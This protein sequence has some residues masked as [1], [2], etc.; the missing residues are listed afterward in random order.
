MLLR[1]RYS[2]KLESQ[3]AIDHLTSTSAK[4]CDNS[5]ARNARARTHQSVTVR[6]L[7]RC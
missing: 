6:V 4:E 3:K 5:R 2:S 1:T 7:L